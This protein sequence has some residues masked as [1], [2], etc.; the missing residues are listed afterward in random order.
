MP[1]LY[2]YVVDHNNDPQYARGV[3]SL[4]KDTC[5]W[6]IRNIAIRGDWVIARANRNLLCGNK[7][8]SEPN[9]NQSTIDLHKS[10]VKE[11]LLYAMQ[12]TGKKLMPSLNT[13]KPNDKKYILYSTNFWAFNDLLKLPQKH[14]W[15][16]DVIR[17]HKKFNADSKSV[18]SFLSWL[19]KQPKE[20]PLIFSKTQTA[21]KNKPKC[22]PRNT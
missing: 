19:E 5:K 18:K 16:I 3:L 2:S 15:I 4:G 9:F 17:N 8:Y 1:Q 10:D 7:N 21:C 11:C 13:P 12:I 20:I 14:K 6:R 22:K